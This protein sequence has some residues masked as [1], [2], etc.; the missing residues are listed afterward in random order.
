MPSH[1]RLDYMVC[2]KQPTLSACSRGQG[3]YTAPV[4]RVSLL[5]FV[6]GRLHPLG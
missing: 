1:S 3:V 6:P 2:L 4:Q 5:G